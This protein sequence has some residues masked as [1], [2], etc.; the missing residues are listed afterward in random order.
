MV[1]GQHYTIAQD[2]REITVKSGKF[3]NIA[4]IIL[5]TLRLFL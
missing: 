1:S 5:G 4:V 3:T 2:G